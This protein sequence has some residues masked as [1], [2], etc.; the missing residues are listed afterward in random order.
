MES[1]QHGNQPTDSELEHFNHFMTQRCLAMKKG[2]EDKANEMNTEQFFAL[3]NYM[4]CM[5]YTSFDGQYLKSKWKL[6]KKSKVYEHSDMVMMVMKVLKC[7]RNDA[8]C[9]LR[10]GNIDKDTIKEVY[11]KIYEPERIKFRHK[12]GKKS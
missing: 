1:R 9:Y 11:I 12:K 10:N 6:S 8:E 5:A 3:P 7:S 4:Q 2:Y